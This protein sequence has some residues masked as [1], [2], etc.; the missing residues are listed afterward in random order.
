MRA[1]SGAAAVRRGIEGRRFAT[2]SPSAASDESHDREI[3]FHE[4]ERRAVQVQPAQSD[5]PCDRRRREERAQTRDKTKAGG[6]DERFHQERP[7]YSAWVRSYGMMLSH[8]SAEDRATKAT[9]GSVSLM[10]NTSWGT[11]GLM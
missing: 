3:R 10:L 4:R 2:S 8:S 9:T 6:E 1:T 5:R 11:P 7:G